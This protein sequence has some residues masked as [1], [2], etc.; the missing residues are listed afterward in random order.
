MFGW[1]LL[2]RGFP[3]PARKL[4]CGAL[5]ISSV[6][7]ILSAGVHADNQAGNAPPAPQ[8]MPV[9]APTGFNSVTNGFEDQASFDKDRETFEEVE[10]I[11]PNGLG[12]V[13]NATSC[14]SC[15]QNPITGSSSQIAE[16]RVGHHEPD[17]NDPGR[18]IFI[19]PPSGSLIHQR[20]IDA[21]IQEHVL[22]G[23][24]VHT[25][26]MSTSILGNG[27]IEVIPDADILKIRAAQP[28]GM[29]GLPVA[30]PVVVGVNSGTGEFETVER[31]GRFGWKC[32]E[33]SLINFSAGAYL[34]EMGVTSPLQ[35]KENTSNGRDVSQYDLV[36]DPEDQVDPQD[37]DNQAHPF[38]DDIKTFTR[39]MRSTKAPSREFLALGSHEV[40]EGEK[41]F[42][43]NDALGCAICHYPDHT[44]PVAGTPI[45]PLH[46]GADSKPGSDMK[47]VPIALGN[48][49]IH[50]YSD[51]ML[52]DIGTGDGIAQ[53]QHAQRPPRGVANLQKVPDEIMT[54]EGIA[55]VRARD[56][57]GD[58][59]ALS[60]DVPGLDQRTV[61]MVRTAPLWGLRVR[62]QLLHDG[63][64]L[65]IDEA[66][67]RH[68]GQAEEVTMKYV[69]MATEHPEQARQ[70]IAFLKSL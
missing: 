22:P 31:L 12:P 57:G 37:P 4:A 15:H 44:T 42:R 24:E 54:R 59:R 50:P 35:P 5:G 43:N 6:A 29:K 70:L 13:Y 67:R 41:L 27:Y 38:G 36:A 46:G 14:V 21:T 39:F 40:Q 60:P 47:V 65:S 53:T 2:R 68:H 64:A 49:I 62:P 10:A 17:P 20:A 61:N 58:R 55:R 51:F 26:R 69:K 63:S 3:E 56:F 28:K 48:K 30:V 25:L 16:L 45:L 9:E 11:T 18:F 7:L 66:I 33:A 8:A 1:S 23:Y 19:E 52:H 34:N 32:Q